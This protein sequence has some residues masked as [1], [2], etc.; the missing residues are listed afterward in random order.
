MRV[1]HDMPRQMPPAPAAELTMAQIR[2]LFL[3]QRAGPLPMGRIAEMFDLSSTAA[4]GF[5]G[6]VERHGLVERRH[7]DD[8]RRIVECALTELGGRFVDGMSG[9]RLEAIKGALEILTERELSGLR[10]IM[11][12]IRSRQEGLA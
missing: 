9:L 7:R 3:L 2:L 6:R 11:K 5:V 12:R 8:D 1:L 10:E 4:T